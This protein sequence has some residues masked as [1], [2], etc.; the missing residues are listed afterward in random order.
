MN[1]KT[2]FTINFFEETI[3]GTKTSFNRAGRGI[4]PYYEELTEKPFA[5]TQ[6]QKTP[7]L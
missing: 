3:S 2:H 7:T 6:T 5:L 1:N 4:S